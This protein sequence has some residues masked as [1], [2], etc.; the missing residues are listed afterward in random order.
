[1]EYFIDREEKKEYFINSEGRKVPLILKFY[2]TQKDKK[3]NY[4]KNEKK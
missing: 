3:Q 2:Y 1:M 4:K